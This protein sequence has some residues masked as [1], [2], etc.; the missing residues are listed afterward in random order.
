MK[1][2]LKL[3][4]INGRR[5]EIVAFKPNKRQSNSSFLK[6]LGLMQRLP[7]PT[8]LIGITKISASNRRL[9]TIALDWH[10]YKLFIIIMLISFLTLYSVSFAVAA[11]PAS[12][13]FQLEE[14]G[15]GA[16]GI[17][18]ASSTN[19]LFSGIAGEVETASLSSANYIALPGLSYTEQPNVPAPTLTNPANYYNKL[20]LVINN[21]NY[22]ADTVF[23]VQVSSGSADFSQNVFYVEADNTLGA[24]IYFQSYTS[25]GSTSGI[26]L[27]GLNPGTTYYARVTAKRG[28]FQQGPWSATANAATVNPTLTFNVQTSTQTSPPFSVSIGTITPGTVATSQDQITATISTNATN[29]GLV[30]IYGANN[31]LKS[32]NAANYTITS[33]TNDLSTA[34]E[35]YGAQ[36]TSVTQTT[37]GPMEFDS[38]YNGTGNNVGVIN[39]SKMVLSDSSNNPVSGGQTSFE[40]KAKAGATT[41][42][43]NDYTDTLTLIGTG[44]F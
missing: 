37:G 32:T 20:H 38:P 33:S 28:T 4:E 17:A 13:N 24:N 18:S 14:Y 11:N 26:D 39:T 3:V 44:S 43:A 19:Y 2:H 16:G 22:P 10:N 1:H 15:F 7:R 41:P 40:L 12:T 27:V 42:S 8:E 34:I 6:I 30:Y 35:G 36:G 25:W 9:K 5:Q 21:A 23:A 31:G 29:G